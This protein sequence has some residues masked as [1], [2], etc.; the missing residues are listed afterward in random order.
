MTNNFKILNK[1]YLKT[2]IKTLI[3]ILL[4]LESQQCS[5][6]TKTN[7]QQKDTL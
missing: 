4:I 7:K 1:Y 5:N 2:L 3:K 6:I